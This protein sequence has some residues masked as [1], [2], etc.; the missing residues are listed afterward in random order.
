MSYHMLEGI[1]L[2]QMWLDEKDAT[3]KNLIKPANNL[4]EVKTKIF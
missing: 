2:K 3:L 4:P 1:L